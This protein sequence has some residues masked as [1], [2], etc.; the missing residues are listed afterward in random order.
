MLAACGIARISVVRK[1]R[2]AVLSTGDEL[3]QP[4]EPL[5]PPRSMTAT[6][7]SSPRR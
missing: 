1:P 6:A 4:G 5:R 2:V 7:P 3:M